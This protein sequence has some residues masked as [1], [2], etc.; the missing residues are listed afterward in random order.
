M[1]LSVHQVESGD[2]SLELYRISNEHLQLVFLPSVGGRLLSLQ[3]AGEE[4]L[5]INPDFFD[6]EFRAL[7]PRLSWATLDGT[8]A[9]WANV[10]APRPGRHRKGKM[11]GIGPAHRILS[12]TRAS[13]P[14]N[15]PGSQL[16]KYN[17]SS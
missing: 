15:P 7:R 6:R 12:S 10:G 9:S 11:Q 2:P 13:G 3:I 4:L 1:T 5:W 14:S 8:F 16:R 17:R